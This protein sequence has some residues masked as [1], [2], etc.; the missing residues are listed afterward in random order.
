[1]TEGLRRSTVWLVLEAGQGAK[2]VDC[3]VV[4]VKECLRHPQG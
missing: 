4:P 1:M 3:P 2:I